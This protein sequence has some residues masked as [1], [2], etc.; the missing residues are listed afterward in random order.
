MLKKLFMVGTCLAAVPAVCADAGQAYVGIGT[1]ATFAKF[2]QDVSITNMAGPLF[3]N[4][5]SAHAKQTSW[6]GGIFLGYT[7]PIN[8]FS[9]GGELGAD[10]GKTKVSNASALLLDSH[11]YTFQIH[12]NST[13]Y[14]RA[15]LGFQA[16]ES[17]AIYALLGAVNSDFNLKY[18]DD[19]SAYN[20]E[21]RQDS[22]KKSRLWGFAPG[23][24]MEY[25]INKQWSIGATYTYENYQKF[26][27]TDFSTYNG[28]VGAD[29]AYFTESFK[30]IIQ[31]FMVRLAYKF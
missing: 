4:A 28:G 13:L 14:V 11:P 15:K 22:S 31:S 2:A 17:F 8:S 27:S 19:N 29:P 20:D 1:G 30:P 3:D 21:P 7:C 10:F 18:F 9:L 12:R 16:T 26:K 23:I 6:R 5:P 24:E 25:N